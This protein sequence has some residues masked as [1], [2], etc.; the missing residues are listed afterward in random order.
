ML[1]FLGLRVVDVKMA[2]RS[3]VFTG[4][5]ILVPGLLGWLTE[6]TKW[7]PGR[8]FPDT[9]ALGVLAIAA[10]AAAAAAVLTAVWRAVENQLGKG[11]LRANP[12]KPTPRRARR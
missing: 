3:G 12:P 10:V 11:F 8:P 2:V 9:Q 1:E 7:A 6:W 4:L 5:A